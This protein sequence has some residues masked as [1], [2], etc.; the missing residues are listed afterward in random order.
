MFGFSK[1]SSFLALFFI[2]FFNIQ[3]VYGR[4]QF[5][6]LEYKEYSN[7]VHNCNN[8][9]CIKSVPFCQKIQCKYEPCEPG[10]LLI[11]S[12]DQCCPTCQLPKNSCHYEGYLINHNT[13]FSPKI[14]TTCKCKNGIMEC[15]E[16][17]QDQI[18]SEDKLDISIETETNNQRKELRNL[19]TR[20]KSTHKYSFELKTEEKTQSICYHDN[21]IYQFNSTWSPLK[22]TQCKCG[23]NSQVDC[24]VHECPHLNCPNGIEI[25]PN[26]CC[27]KCKPI[28]TCQENGIYYKDGDYW[29]SKN[30]PCLHCSC[31]GGKIN[32]IK[33]NCTQTQ[34]KKNE[35]LVTRSNRCCAQ[36]ESQM[37]ENCD[38][39]G[40]LHY[41]GEMWYTKGCQHCSC[42]SGRV[43]CMNVQCEST[44]CLK[45]EIIVQKK[46]ECCITCRKPKSCKINEL[47]EIQENDFYTTNSVD[48]QQKKS[49]N[50]CK[51]CQCIN[52]EMQCYTKSCK[53]SKYPTYAH[54]NVY[55]NEKK[56]IN[57]RTIPFMTD[58]IKSINKDSFVYVTSGPKHSSL[59]IE[60]KKINQFKI[61]DIALS[62]VY[63]KINEDI[64]EKIEMDY[65]V[66]SIMS[67]DN[68]T[69]Y[70]V[71]IEFE[72]LKSESEEKIDF[73]KILKKDEN[74]LPRSLKHLNQE[75]NSNK[76]KNLQPRKTIFIQ[77][78]ESIKLTSSELR[79][80]NIASGNDRLV[81]H[82]VSAR[83]KYGDLKLKKVFSDDIVPIGWHKVNDL[84]LEKPVDEFVQSDLDNGNVWYEPFNNFKINCDNN[85]K[86]CDD[87]D[88]AKYD[89][90][91]FEVYIEGKPND[92]ISKEIIHFSI[93]NE[94][95]ND[96][97]LGLEVIEN[98]ITPLTFSNFD[99]AGIDSSRD[100]LIYRIIKTLDKSQGQLE[101]AANPGIP[102][103]TF[104][105]A[106]L[107]K[108]LI[109]YHSPKE[110]GVNVREF[111]FTFVVTNDNRSDTFPETPFHVKVLPANDQAPIFK[112]PVSVINMLQS[113]SVTLPRDIFD[114][115]DPDTSLEN[116]IFTIEKP[117]D[118]TV[119][120][121]RSKGQRYVISKEDSFT[122]QE[123]RDG[124]FRL[125]HNGAF[126]QQDLFKISVSDNK[127]ISVKTININVQLVDNI[128][129]RIYERSTMLLSLK[130]GQTKNIRRDNLA[131]IDDH[132]S[133]EEIFYKIKMK[134]KIQ[135]R[136]LNRDKILIGNSVFTQADIDLQNIKYEAPQE[137]GQN[138]LT[139]NLIFDVMDKEGNMLKDQ[140][141][142]IKV[143]PINNQAPV[144]DVIQEMKVQEGGYLI[145]NESF[146]QVKDVDSAK[147][148]LNVIIDSQPSFGYLE[149]IHKGM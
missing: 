72:L 48:L 104:T 149:N 7:W 114:V 119:I 88:Q 123:I 29:T 111:F 3:F 42:V 50:P 103:D 44:F 67:Y 77:P 145:I 86:L 19:K 120:E 112:D 79:P 46:D 132:S 128:A 56:F 109:L 2:L 146:I 83:P 127:H 33:E 129:P 121:L 69:A 113:G 94:V 134:S 130:E 12:D 13:E 59:F 96:T 31:L 27:P 126:T 143:E 115:E 35:L 100:Y 131:Y 62:K 8:C 53:N 89:H 107:N 110:I 133:P 97:V 93:Q 18:N 40:K 75:K 10:K 116:L 70:N 58:F 57:A 118:N 71:L 102:I 74:L 4:C 25:D 141:F 14:C 64:E 41:N 1:I 135:G 39:Y 98:Q 28:F 51:I 95:I 24:Y 34:C 140:A 73:F 55:L 26:S 9:T 23:Y 148:Q 43:I 52:G 66:I 20:N 68:K 47:I 136:V 144:V 91:M 61:N 78:G 84:Y 117:P 137:I 105:Q 11:L 65:V 60:D 45:D 90:C 49:T 17:C 76:N 81:Y 139:E 108:G 16:T 54:L 22:C 82:L 87:Q 36:C 15:I 63:Y 124:T 92:V 21:K 80:K 106:D 5:N 147:E 85:K 122:I 37:N 6:E 142:T 38:Y 99:I 125:I 30:D 138:I 101:H 32:C